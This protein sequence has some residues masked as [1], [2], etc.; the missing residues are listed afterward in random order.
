MP[1]QGG[2]FPF[3]FMHGC[4]HSASRLIFSAASQQLQ[5]QRHSEYSALFTLGSSFMRSVLHKY[6]LFF[7]YLC[8]CYFYKA[9]QSLCLVKTG[10]VF[11][12]YLLTCVGILGESGR[13]CTELSV[14]QRARRS[15]VF[16]LSFPSLTVQV[17]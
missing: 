13:Q 14:I 12:F 17:L 2:F 8:C 4:I 15:L 3:P 1:V 10:T 9:P 11:R 6:L 5:T 7:Y 16:I